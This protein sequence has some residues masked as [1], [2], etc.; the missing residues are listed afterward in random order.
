MK[1]SPCPNCQGAN[2]YHTVK[3]V[4]GGGGHAPN[5]LPG[6][7]SFF[8]RPRFDVV[9]CSDCG[10]TRFFVPQ[11]FLGSLQDSSKWEVVVSVR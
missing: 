5:Y 2:L 7:G 3:P 1:R 9:V 6:L 8:R 11:E 10:L 4:H